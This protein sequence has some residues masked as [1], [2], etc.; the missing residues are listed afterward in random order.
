MITAV[1]LL[2]VHLG[3]AWILMELGAPEYFWAV[4]LGMMLVEV[5]WFLTRA[6]RRS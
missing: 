5:G 1:S 4:P 6:M 3:A 2:P